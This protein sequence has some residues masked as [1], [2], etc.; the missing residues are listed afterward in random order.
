MQR[1]FGASHRVLEV[2]MLFPSIACYN[3]GDMGEDKQKD[4]SP[5][6]VAANLA[7]EIRNVASKAKNEEELK[8]IQASLRAFGR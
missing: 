3:V 7:G 8:D 5:R 1:Q 4:L 6:A 2:V